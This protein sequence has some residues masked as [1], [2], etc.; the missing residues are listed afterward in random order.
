MSVADDEVLGQLGWTRGENTHVISEENFHAVVSQFYVAFVTSLHLSQHV[1]LRDPPETD[2]V[3][4]RK[5]R[6]SLNADFIHLLRAGVDRQKTT[7]YFVAALLP[8]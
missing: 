6:T 8:F 4:Q 2:V 1:V 3:K 7:G 5:S